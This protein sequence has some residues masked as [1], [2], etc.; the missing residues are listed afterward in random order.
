MMQSRS[1]LTKDTTKLSFVLFTPLSIAI[2]IIII[3]ITPIPL[4]PQEKA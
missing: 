1:L 4:K 3:G 2:I